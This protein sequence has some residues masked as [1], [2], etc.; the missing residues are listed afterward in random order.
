VKNGGQFTIVAKNCLSSTNATF[1]I[2]VLVSP[3]LSLNQSQPYVIG[4]KDNVSVCGNISGISPPYIYTVLIRTSE[5]TKIPSYLYKYDGICWTI[6]NSVVKDGGRF[7]I[8]I[9]SKLSSASANASFLVMVKPAISM[10]FTMVVGGCLDSN[11]SPPLLVALQGQNVAI[12]YAM[13][14][15]P[16]PTI[17]LLNANHSQSLYDEVRSN[18]GKINS[19]HLLL[20][21]VSSADS[22]MYRVSLR[23]A[24]GSDV[25]NFSLKIVRRKEVK[26]MCLTSSNTKGTCSL[27]LPTEN[28]SLISRGTPSASVAERTLLHISTFLH[29]TNNS[30]TLISGSPEDERTDSTEMGL[31]VG[32]RIAIGI[33]V[34]MVVIVPIILLYMKFRRKVFAVN[35]SSHLYE[36]SKTADYAATVIYY[37]TPVKS[38]AKAENEYMETEKPE[39][40]HT[41]NSTATD[42]YYSYARVYPPRCGSSQI[43]SERLGGN[44]KDI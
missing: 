14:G 17:E 39:A 20:R 35:P 8:E 16:V 41:T 21:N 44:T 19:T 34:S 22:G 3:K 12:P 13:M 10:N 25:Q 2:E 37:E 6:D 15:F 7:T 23:N 26:V 28:H 38:D 5:Q 31:S 18:L 33:G 29:P 4:S 24:V 32:V 40:K 30:F 1:S 36:N 27:Q 9:R 11:C 42:G 43:R